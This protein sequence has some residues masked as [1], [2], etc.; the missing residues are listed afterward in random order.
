MQETRSSKH[1]D[2]EDVW[3]GQVVVVVARWFLIGAG[4]LLTL[5]R[6]DRIEDITTP[7]YLLLGLI[8][9][10]F[11]MHGRFLMGSPMRR[12]VVMASC[13]V[14]AVIVTL[15]IAASSWKAEPG[16]ANPCY[17][18]YYP[19]LLAFALVFPWRTTLLYA[20]GVLGAYAALVL[21]ETSALTMSDYEAL[22]SRLVTMGATAVLGTIYWRMQRRMR[23]EELNPTRAEI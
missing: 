12:E 5:W 18:F 22:I 14:D 2:V 21:S 6:A 13:V 8:A 1:E 7:L 4:V 17:V 20:A 23:R 19:V 11:F 9:L 15:V 10:N 16:I 3:Y